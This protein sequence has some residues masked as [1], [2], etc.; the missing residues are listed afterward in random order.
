MRHIA[1]FLSL[2][3]LG[4]TAHGWWD[5]QVM[6]L[7]EPPR[8]AH[9]EAES[10][11]LSDGA[12]VVE[13]A[14]PY[15]SAVGGDKAV[16]VDPGAGTLTWSVALKPSTYRLFVIGRVPG[17]RPW[18]N[19]EP[20]WP[21][22]VKVDVSCP[23][24]KVGSWT[25]P[26]NYLNTYYDIARISFP[27]HV[28][29]DYTV[30]LSITGESKT[31]LWIDRLDLRDELGNTDKTGYKTGRYLHSDAEALRHI[32]RNAAGDARRALNA[33]EIGVMTTLPDEE[34]NIRLTRELSR[35]N[36]DLLQLNEKL[37]QRVAVP[38]ATRP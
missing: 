16:H 25:M 9:A 2:A 10:L 3:F 30:S 20:E 22:F 23:T 1:F 29:S 34:Q 12:E 33:L 13:D 11:A 24:G 7:C 38:E 5:T 18:E 28:A 26:A 4:A 27:A 14:V 37:E 31:A 21:L 17:A 36:E 19:T 32:A 6:Y 15:G 35:K 8:I